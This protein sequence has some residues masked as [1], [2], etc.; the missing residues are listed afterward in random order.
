MSGTF[1]LNIVLPIKSA[2]ELLDKDKWH[3][4][5]IRQITAFQPQTCITLI[6]QETMCGQYIFIK[7][8]F[9]TP[10]SVFLWE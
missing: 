4:F 2:I 7:L 5:C 10:V 1:Q 8:N 3:L 6:I 9:F